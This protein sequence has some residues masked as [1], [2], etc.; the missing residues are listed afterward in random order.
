[1]STP[2]LISPLLDNFI[3]GDPIS[4]HHGI[5]CCPAMLKDT[6]DKFIV[7]IISIPASQ[8]KLDALL[9]TGAY[10]SADAAQ[11]YF[12]DLTK[13]LV[14][15]IEILQ[16]LSGQEGFVCCEGYQIVPMDE[17]TGFDIY[18]LTKYRRSMERH[19]Q[20]T[21][22]THLDALNLALDMCS[23]LTACRRS[24]YLYCD[25]KPGN[26]FVTENKEYRI[27][28]IGFI[29]LNAMRF[30]TLPENNISQYTPPEIT[31]AFSS[32]NDRIDIYALGA[33][34]YQIYSGGNL[35]E[36]VSGAIPDPKFADE[37][38]SQ[39]I[40]KALDPDPQNRWE[41]PAQMG[42]AI[43]GYMQRNGAS[44]DLIV[45]PAPPVSEPEAPQEQEESIDD[46][47]ATVDEIALESPI[48]IPAAESE[49]EASAEPSA[50]E[51]TNESDADESAAQAS[52]ESED[53]VQPAETHTDD[54]SVSYTEDFDGNLSFLNEEL[55]S[56]EDVTIRE[57]DSSAEDISV[58]LSDSVVTPANAEDEESIADAPVDDTPVDDASVD[59]TSDA[60]VQA[61]EGELSDDSDD[62]A[63][64]ETPSEAASEPE[65]TDE[66][67][68]AAAIKDCKDSPEEPAPSDEGVSDVLEDTIVEYDE[69][70]D[71]KPRKRWVKYLVLALIA[72][73]L[74]VGGFLFY[75]FYY[76]QSIDSLEVS[77]SKDKLNVTV[78]S[79]ID[80]A[81]LSVVC[82]NAVYG[83]AVEAPVVNGVAQFSGLLADTEYVVTVKIDGFHQL[84]GQTSASYFS[85]DESSIVQFNALTGGVD[86]SADLTFTLDGPDSENWVI[87]YSADGTEEMSVQLSGHSV[88]LTGLTVGAEYTAKL[89]PVDDLYLTG[90]TEVVFVA[91]NVIQAENLAITSL[92]NG[93]L[94]ASW[95]VP[96]NETVE[97]WRVRCFDNS[98]YD[99]TITTNDTSVVFTELD[100]TH[101]F[102][103]EVTA[104][105]QSVSATTQIGENAITLFELAAD[106]SSLGKITLK[107]E[108]T[109]VPESGWLVTYETAGIQKT[110]TTD[111]NSVSIVSALPELEY[112]FTIAAADG[113]P[114]VYSPIS[115]TTPKAT[116]FSREYQGISVTR[117]NLVFGM[118]RTPNKSNWDYT[119][120]PGSAYTR[121]FKANQKASF[122]IFLN[123]KYGISSEMIHTTFAFYND[124]GVLV[125]F[126]TSSR[127]WSDMWYKNYC[128]MEIPTMPTEAGSYT[129][130]IYF[131]G[132][133]I[134]TQSFS[135]SE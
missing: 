5:R 115:C 35:P 99:K 109:A 40:M 41:D 77:G 72:A 28:D 94:S 11:E 6:D 91:S 114:V 76:L 84:T 57:E 75:R 21:A 119:D 34:L 14:K 32:L 104:I 81:L 2:K 112:T 82:E 3:M 133:Y 98:G 31:D 45:P 135:I 62:N 130:Q 123:R 39:I 108:S 26:I 132:Q 60:P 134:T 44:D 1:M 68:L 117:N 12:K 9:L 103:V 23:A 87:T 4:D 118:C 10:P 8:T 120:V 16:K 73:A 97:G 86:G 58:A 54:A 111:N 53:V 110:V 102:T 93:E 127:E 33:I 126:C 90:A 70:T 15:Q 80:E 61:D 66:E 52:D 113:S 13:D 19:M 106:T 43:I 83:R 47:L 27:G 65:M 71:A 25:L 74:L 107:W 105:G 101:A 69:E 49:S 50:E 24:G 20:K 18:I 131:N 79:E 37:E 29:D 100:G 46:I 88:T 30:A 124:E 56:G 64:E 55:L 67:L 121:V 125:D 122:I 89:Q 92:V 95:T 38:I 7:K 96:E 85:P 63:V 17:G 51:I 42:Q 128:E 78:V 22:L 116:N 59:N 129:V 48:Q 36:A